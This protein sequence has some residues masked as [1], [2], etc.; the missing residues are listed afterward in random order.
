MNTNSKEL[1]PIMPPTERKNVPLATYTNP[2]ILFLVTFQQKSYNEKKI[3]IAWNF[4]EV[5]YYD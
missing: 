2:F 5:V 1:D 3:M 4:A